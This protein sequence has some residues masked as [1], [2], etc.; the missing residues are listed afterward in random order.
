MGLGGVLQ[1]QVSLD[2]TEGSKEVTLKLTG[3]QGDTMKE[4]AQVALSVTRDLKLLRL[5]IRRSTFMF[6][7]HPP[8]R[9]ARQPVLLYVVH[10]LAPSLTEGI[11][12]DVCVTGEVCLKGKVNAV[13]GIGAKFR[14]AARAG[15][16]KIVFPEENRRDVERLIKYE[17]LDMTGVGTS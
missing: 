4:S 13:G 17:A 1:V 2:K 14:A 6:L 7:M 5:N 16:K 15:A 9:M 12:R 8:L 3:N 10:C 11:K